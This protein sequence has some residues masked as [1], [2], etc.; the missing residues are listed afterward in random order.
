MA[1]AGLA[2][3]AAFKVEGENGPIRSGIDGRTSALNPD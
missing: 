2:R 3:A 1:G